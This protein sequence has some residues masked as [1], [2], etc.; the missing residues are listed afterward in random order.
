M[1]DAP[2]DVAQTAEDLSR[3]ARLTT[4]QKSQSPKHGHLCLQICDDGQVPEWL[5]PRGMLE[6]FQ[7]HKGEGMG[8]DGLGMACSR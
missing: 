1:M 3:K 5:D 4:E 2:S 7:G 6:W 8:P